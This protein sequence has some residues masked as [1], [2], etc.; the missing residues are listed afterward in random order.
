MVRRSRNKAT[1]VETPGSQPHDVGIETQMY[2]IL[3]LLLRFE[4]NMH[5]DENDVRSDL[6]YNHICTRREQRLRD[7]NRRSLSHVTATNTITTTTTTTS[8]TASLLLSPPTTT[9]VQLLCP[10]ASRAQLL[11]CF[12]SYHPTHAHPSSPTS[13]ANSPTTITT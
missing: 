7:T 1:G 3:E 13:T 11:E 5:N 8:T 9:N 4:E 6:A 2:I 12:W 10:A